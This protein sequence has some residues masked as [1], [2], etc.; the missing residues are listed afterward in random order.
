MGD[1]SRKRE[2]DRLRSASQTA[3]GNGSPKVRI[4]AF[5]VGRTLGMLASA[6]RDGRSNTSL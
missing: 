3:I 1:L 2:R 6:G 5:G 4:W